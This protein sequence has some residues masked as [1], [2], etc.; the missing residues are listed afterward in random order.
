MAI[1]P[2]WALRNPWTETAIPAQIGT[3]GAPRYSA[4]LGICFARAGAL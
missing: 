3:S 4:V 2:E 1:A